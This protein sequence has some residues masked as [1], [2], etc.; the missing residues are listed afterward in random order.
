MAI[1]H[2]FVSTDRPAL[3][4]VL[5]AWQSRW[6]AVGV[7]A[8]LPE[9][10]KDAVATLQAAC[11]VRRVPLLGAIFP[12]LIAGA[13]FLTSGAWLIG[14]ERMP[15]SFLLPAR[16]GMQAVA[17]AV[18]GALAEM[19]ADRPPP[20]LFMVFDGM[21]PTIASALHVLFTQLGQRVAYAGVCAGSETFQPMPCLFDAVAVHGDAVLGVLLPAEAGQ[22]VVRHDY[23]VSLSTMRATSAVGNRIER[24]DNRPAFAVY[25]AVIQQEYGVCLTR[26]N[27]Y[28]YAVHFPF[29]LITA[30]DVLVRIPVAFDDAGALY[31]VGEVP[32]N[33]MLRLLKAPLAENSACIAGIAD[34]LGRARTARHP[35]LTF[36]CAGRRM[37]LGAGA[38]SEIEQ[39]AKATGASTLLGALSLGE[40]DQLPDLS[41][42]RFHNAALVCLAL[43]E[44]AL[45]PS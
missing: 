23:P 7:L 14:F 43:Q 19:P 26:E 24:I 16:A 30:V 15:P 34:G 35:V 17:D 18:S 6:P 32:P 12:A 37:H 31:C 22:C 5:E 29:G 33:T 39:L 10:E 36:Y 45:R 27:F 9:A 38:A 4:A 3:D 28:D 25:Q 44:A 41:I 2:Q 40:I 1:S 13:E 20:T 11:R 21:L 42:P 8:L